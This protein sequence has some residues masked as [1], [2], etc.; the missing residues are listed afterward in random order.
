[1]FSKIPWNHTLAIFT[2]N[3]YDETTL[4]ARKESYTMRISLSSPL[5]IFVKV[6]KKTKKIGVIHLV[7]KRILSWFPLK[8]TW[9]FCNGDDREYCLVCACVKCFMGKMRA[10]FYTYS[11]KSMIKFSEVMIC[12]YV[13][14]Y[15]HTCI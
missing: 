13:A 12:A 5:F 8:C 15:M 4:S 14:T 10:I 6:I 7:G 1:M 11:G 3:Q 9:V 2:C